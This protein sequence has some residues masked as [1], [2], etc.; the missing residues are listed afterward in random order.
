[1]SDFA[2]G[3]GTVAVK[4]AVIYYSSTGGTHA[5]AKAATEGAEKAGAEVRLRRVAELAPASVIAQNGAWAAHTAATADV[6][7]ASLGDLDWA[8]VVLFGTPT[9]YG[10]MASQLKQFIDITG[11]L[12]AKGALADKVYSAFVSTATDHGGQETTLHGF[13]TVFTHWG[14]IIVPPGYT[15]PVQM[16]SGNPYGAS[17]ISGSEGDKEL[18]EVSLESARFQA[19]RCVEIA[20]KLIAGS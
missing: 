20:A 12:W 8:D 4:V 11:G 16:A 17:H 14:G 9:R 5:L 13:N 6:P 19:R 3:P 10:T 18:T 15:D 1:M 7:E 2:A